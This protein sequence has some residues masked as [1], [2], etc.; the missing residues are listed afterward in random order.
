MFDVVIINDDIERAY[1]ELKDIL[2][3]VSKTCPCYYLLCC[4]GPLNTHKS[5]KHLLKYYFL[6]L[7]LQEIKKVQE[8]KS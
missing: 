3:E 1:E 8:A 4:S 5:I 7:L 6:T 2:N